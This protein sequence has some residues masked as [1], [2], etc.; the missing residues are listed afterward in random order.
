[1]LRP[2][3]HS[4]R[5]LVV[6]GWSLGAIEVV[7]DM[8]VSLSSGGVAACSLWSQFST[9]HFICQEQIN[10]RFSIVACSG[11]LVALGSLP[12]AAGGPRSGPG[13]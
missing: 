5:R 11:A 2:G 6:T 7:L 4:A 13:L 1:M 3:S 9:E 10:C 12:D 8:S